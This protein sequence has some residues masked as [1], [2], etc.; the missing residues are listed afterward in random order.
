[1][2]TLGLAMGLG[3]LLSGDVGVHGA[4]ST[5]VDPLEVLDLQVRNNALIVFD[6]SGSM[7]WPPENS[8]DIGGDDPNSRMY[9]AK[10]AVKAVVSANANLMNFG[11]ASYNVLKSDKDLDDGGNAELRYVSA[12]DTAQMFFGS[13]TCPRGPDPLVPEEGFFCGFDNDFVDVDGVIDGAGAGGNTSQ[14]AY[15]SFETQD[16]LPYPPGCVG[17][18]CD[19]YYLQSA[20][21]RHRVQFE[22][23]LTRTDETT[24]LRNAPP[25]TVTGTACSDF[26]PAGLTGDNPDANGDGIADE[27][28]PWIKMVDFN[29]GDFACFYFSGG[30]FENDGGSSC[31]GAAQLSVVAP[32][33]GDNSQIVLNE[34]G[35]EMPVGDYLS[36]DNF[37]LGT[38]NT[39][40]NYNGF[41]VPVILP[42]PAPP[43]APTNRPTGLRSGQST[44][45]AAS[46]EN[47]HNPP[48][49]PFFPAQAN[50]Q[51]KNF[52]I[53]LT[54]GDER[55]AAG[56]VDDVAQ[57]AFDLYTETN[58]QEQ[59]ELIFI[60][61]TTA[62]NLDD[63]N[64][65]ARAGSGGTTGGSCAS[66][67]GP[68]R[69]AFLAT[70]TDELINV[71][72]NALEIAVSSGT[73]S[74]SP[75]VV[76]TVFEL[77]TANGADPLDPDTRYNDRSNVFFLPLFNL[78]EWDG[79]LRAFLND[80][81]ASQ[82][83]VGGTTPW[84][85]GQSLIDSVV[86]PMQ[87][88]SV[89]G[90]PANRF[91]FSELH[92]G[93]D[94]RTIGGSGALIKRRIFTSAGG[95]R[96][97]RTGAQ[98]DSPTA[99]GSNVVALWPPNQAGLTPADNVGAALPAID[100]PLGT[101]GPLDDA[102]GIGAGSSPVRTFAELQASLGVCRSSS[103]PDPLN[104]GAPVP[105][106]AA[107]A[108]SDL[109][110]ARKE[111]RQVILAWIAGTELVRGLDTLPLRNGVSGP[112]FG[113]L[114]YQARSTLMVDSTLTQP[115]VMS[116]PFG[117]TP[118]VH[119]REWI[120]YRDG[121]RNASREGVPADLDLGFGLRNPDFDDS[122]PETKLTLKP[123]MT[124]VYYGTNLLLHAINAAT[125]EELWAY[126]AFDLLDN[127]L[128]LIRN[129]QTRANHYYGVATPVRV[130][131]VFV[132][133]PFTE[134]TFTFNGRWRTVLIFGRGSGGK[135]LTA[136][137]VTAPG[138]FTRPSLQTNPPWVMWSRG[139]PDQ[140]LAGNAVR[141]ADTT[142]YGQM[143]ETWSVPAVGNVDEDALGAP[144]WRLWVGSGYTDDAGDGRTF[145][146]MD[147]VTGDV[148]FSQDVDAIS[149]STPGDISTNAIVASPAG[150]NSFQLD[151]P[152][153]LTRGKDL[154]SRVYFPDLHGRVWKYLP[155]A[156]VQP[157]YDAGVDQPFTEA[158][159]LAKLNNGNFVYVGSGRDTRV[160]Q[161]PQFRIYGIED[162]EGDG[163]NTL[164]AG[165]IA[166]PRG[167]TFEYPDLFRNRT[168]PA[169][170]FNVAGNGR[171]FFVGQRFNPASAACITSFDTL[172]FALGAESGAYIYDFD[173]SGGADPYTIKTGTPPG[174]V[175]VQGG[176]VE[177]A[178]LGG[179]PS[180]TP[181]SKPSPAP[182]EEPQ[183]ITHSQTIGSPVCRGGY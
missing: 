55:C 153:T 103:D 17:A 19:V 173:G 56:G 64:R 49:T 117:A 142:P 36:A 167:F 113:E 135:H 175:S 170:A 123:R 30:I 21:F 180:P 122:N 176:R 40:V 154:V 28:R 34:M 57:E 66:P 158:A 26:P 39:P 134:G 46:L 115:A 75:S 22:W 82:V 31:G 109:A 159:A 101:A 2:A 81:S 98:F 71:L 140:D 68:C 6:T 128:N 97:P 116:P 164:L 136:L 152:G 145:Y 119:G 89:A 80:G 102:L 107:C 50:P 166:P 92:A 130:A 157:F 60:A 78:P 24:V 62:V 121:H 137:D 41:D 4:V 70:N 94:A 35:P 111:A 47:I 53:L 88:T 151:P 144:E 90:R 86:T 13:F 48:G 23:D 73:F 83:L 9:Q 131:D 32:C 146:E 161:P 20:L 7:R 168:Q 118:E 100:P 93:A 125:A 183:I 8:D 14:E 42:S 155:G 58:F 76:G 178:T 104:G 95:G 69:D 1:M 133:V 110:T 169:V 85:A 27:R 162:P 74:A 65:V 120:L 77:G 138:P 59:A 3:L 15:R 129:G 52:V 16:F 126:L 51:Q 182:P 141:A 25:F 143:G 29:S 96:F 87:A 160:D 156:S 163:G 18:A 165:S 174:S 179:Q 38:A 11:L 177:V 61:F 45:L 171:V 150:W 72:Q 63:A 139:N 124:V 112:E 44:P 172:L 84:N 181:F 105:A 132:P 79:E 108:T 5:G 54:D 148:L 147:V 106:P 43:S 99:S 67:T 127:P 37:G 12:D 114:L 91:T 33:T 149:A 10:Q